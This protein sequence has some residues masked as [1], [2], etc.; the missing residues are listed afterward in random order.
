MRVPARAYGFNRI[1]LPLFE[2][3]R[4]LADARAVALDPRH[5]ERFRWTV[6]F[7]SGIMCA[8]S[9]YGMHLAAARVEPNPRSSGPSRAGDAASALESP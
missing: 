6:A 9:T 5:A 4:D 1:D 8:Q 2:C 3:Q 7:L